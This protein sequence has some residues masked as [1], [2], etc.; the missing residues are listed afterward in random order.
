MKTLIEVE[1]YG[2]TFTVTSEYEEA[3][4]RSLAAYVDRAMRQAGENSK[5]IVPL[6][7]AIMAALGIAEEYHKAVQREEELRQ[8]ADR[9]AATIL[10]RLEQCEPVRAGGTA[11][12]LINVVSPEAPLETVGKE[13][14]KD[15]LF[16]S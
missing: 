8:E 7:V 11:E 1:I 9:L 3:Y 4:V 10:K 5:T 12:P 14:K 15:T 2:Q 16:P 6:R 13:K